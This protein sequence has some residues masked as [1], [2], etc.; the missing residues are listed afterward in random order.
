MVEN[1]HEDGC[2]MLICHPGYLDKF[3]LDNSSL[4]VPR[5]LEVYMLSD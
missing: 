3:I 5:I 1:N 2:D 4:T